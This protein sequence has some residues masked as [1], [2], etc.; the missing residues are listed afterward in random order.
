VFVSGVLL[1]YVAFPQGAKP[2]QVDPD[3][4]HNLALMYLPVIGGFYAV[5]ITCLFLYKIDQTVHEE[6]LR[7]LSE[8]AVEART[9]D[10]TIESGAPAATGPA[11]DLSPV[12]PGARTFRAD[13]GPPPNNG[14]SRRASYRLFE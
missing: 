13:D 10:A 7:K 1:A 5:A 4:L 3:L 8:G 14:S 11:G 2:G 6:N 12:A 9:S